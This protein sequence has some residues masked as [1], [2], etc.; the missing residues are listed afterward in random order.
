MLAAVGGR[1][2]AWRAEHLGVVA[3]LGAALSV[4]VPVV[5]GVSVPV[6][7]RAGVVAGVAGRRSHGSTQKTLVLVSL[8]CERG[9][10]TVSFTW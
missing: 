3:G 7:C 8:P 1:P 5:P 4:S 10:A 2:D 9:V 6:R